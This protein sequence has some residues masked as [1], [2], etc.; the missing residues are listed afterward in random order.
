[1]NQTAYALHLFI[2]DVAGEVPLQ[3]AELVSRSNSLTLQ[4]A[5]GLCADT[6]SACSPSRRRLSRPAQ[7]RSGMVK[8][9]LMSFSICY[10]D[11]TNFTAH[12][13][14]RRRRRR[15]PRPQRQPAPH[16]AGLS[17]FLTLIQSRE[18]PDR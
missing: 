17:G 13:C 8:E 16:L 18:G 6:S 15:R 1:V 2:R 9:L 5:P 10:G 3:F 11:C 12:D 14:G 7:D 4:Q